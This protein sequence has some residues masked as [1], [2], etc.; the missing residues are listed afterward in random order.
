MSFKEKN[1]DIQQGIHHQIMIHHKVFT[2]IIPV[3]F[4]IVL[5]PQQS[6]ALQCLQCQK[7]VNPYSDTKG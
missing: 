3:Q 7:R 1:N 2:Y 6:S 5:I 4:Y